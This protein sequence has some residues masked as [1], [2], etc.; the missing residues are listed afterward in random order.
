MYLL[1]IFISYVTIKSSLLNLYGQKLF[2]KVKHTVRDCRYFMNDTW[3]TSIQW[4]ELKFIP[5]IVERK[6]CFALN[7]IG[8][9]LS[10]YFNIILI[11][12]DRPEM[13]MCYKIGFLYSLEYILV[14]V[15]ISKWIIENVCT[16]ET[17]RRR[18]AYS[19]AQSQSHPTKPF[20]ICIC[21]QSMNQSS[22]AS[23]N[24]SIYLPSLNWTVSFIIIQTLKSVFRFV[25]TLFV[26]PVSYN[27]CYWST[28]T[29]SLAISICIVQLTNYTNGTQ[30]WVSE[31]LWI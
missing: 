12:N 4:P 16:H 24:N 22:G 25:S 29:F 23:S 13:M 3:S 8:N 1:R 20:A 19:L 6:F 31:L 21:I 18:I 10:P 26:L 7:T 17:N 14:T 30:E 27:S 11:H 15:F 2:S 9:L 28:L 5:H